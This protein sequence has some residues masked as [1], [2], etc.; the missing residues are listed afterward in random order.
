MKKK[1]GLFLLIAFVAAGV[2]LAAQPNLPAHAEEAGPA[3]PE[4]TPTPTPT[5]AATPTPA[6]PGGAAPVIPNLLFPAR[7]LGDMVLG[8]IREP[9]Q[10]FHSLIYDETQTLGVEAGK[11][12]EAP[13]QGDYA[14]VAYSSLYTAAA[15]AVPLFLLRLVL[16][17]WSKMIGE[18]DK[19]EAVIGDWV[20]A[21]FLA[22]LCGPFLDWVARLGWWMMGVSLGETQTLA[23]LFFHDTT[24]WSFY[25]GMT[26]IT[27][28]LLMTIMGCLADLGIILTVGGLITA[29]FLSRVILFLLAVV[30]PSIFVGGVVPQLRWLRALWLK[31]LAIIALI[32]LIAAGIFKASQQALSFLTG[33]GLLANL[34]HLG[35]MLGMVGVLFSVIGILGRIT[36]GATVEAARGLF[37]AGKAIVDVGATAAVAAATGGAGVAAAPAAFG[38]A[39]GEAAMA[40]TAGAAAMG[41]Q[42]PAGAAAV[43]N[44]ANGLSAQEDLGSAL[45]MNRLAGGFR[46][47]GMN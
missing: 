9:I 42:A 31:G 30:G 27:N 18:E 43:A 39:G 35:W 1:R 8:M 25:Q 13:R 41:G 17:Q 5:P 47:L 23:T 26:H 7:T 11:I 40:G 21:G 46:A 29:F 16:Y 4:A 36:L 20:S 38:A 34:I 24:L 14:K 33:T 15:L 19:L 32:P 45:K 10:T 37:Q 2:V 12:L 22:L 3:A 44:G 28:P 6:N